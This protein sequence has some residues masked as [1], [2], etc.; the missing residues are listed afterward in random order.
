MGPPALGRMVAARL[1]AAPDAACL[2]FSVGSLKAAVLSEN[3]ILSGAAAEQEAAEAARRQAMPRAVAIAVVGR[4]V[5][6]LPATTR[7]EVAGDAMLT[8]PAGSF[9]A[10]A[11]RTT[12]TVPLT[13]GVDERTLQFEAKKFPVGVN[14]HNARI[15]DLIVSLSDSTSP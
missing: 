4:T 10:R 2:F 11:S 15:A 5:R 12:F 3:P 13:L 1:G 9:R 6:V 8:L 7:G 14:S